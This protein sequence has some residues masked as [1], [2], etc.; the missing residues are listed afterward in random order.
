MG[1][2]KDTY[3][4][5]PQKNQF[6]CLATDT[7]SD[8]ESE[9]PPSAS[10]SAPSA[11][12]ALAPPAPSPPA[13]AS[14]AATNVATDRESQ[15]RVWITDDVSANRFGVQP[16]PFSSPFTKGSQRWNRPRFQEDGD[17]WTSISWT[18][19]QFVEDTAKSVASTPSEEDDASPVQTLPGG[20]TEFPSLLLRSTIDS[21]PPPVTAAMWAERVKKQ[22]DKAEAAREEKGRLKA[23]AREETPLDDRLSFFRRARVVEE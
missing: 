3:V 5:A 11:P 8:S 21:A 1:K 2:K 16:P 17:G 18:Q 12:S 13:S 19:P 9:V 14:T 22:L 15:Y 23:E 10:A 4:Y 7:D 6:A 20:T